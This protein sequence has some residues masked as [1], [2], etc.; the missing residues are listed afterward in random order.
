MLKP[1]PP[2]KGFLSD[3]VLIRQESFTYLSGK[4]A[5][6][7]T[8]SY[9]WWVPI[10]YTDADEKYFG[11]RNTQPR[12]WLS[13]EKVQVS[14]ATAISSASWIVANVQ[15]SGFYRVNY[16]ER[17]W[18]LLADQLR[19]HH[20]AIHVMNRAHLISDAFALAAVDILPYS[21]PFLMIKYLVEE[22]HF[23]P[24]SS[25]FRALDYIGSMMQQTSHYGDYQ[26]IRHHYQDDSTGV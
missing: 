3:E 26:V 5:E 20:K 16:D 14:I 21:T 15:G 6:N 18:R 1:L 9:R 11:R 25:A 22:N 7:A 24:W 2:I 19:R 12:L 23:V 8:L 13:P 17:N 10:S 4:S